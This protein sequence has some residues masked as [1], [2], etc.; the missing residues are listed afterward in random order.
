[1]IKVS[2]YKVELSE[3][4]V[5]KPLI[6]KWHYSHSV[7]G[8]QI[9][10]CFGLFGE[11][12]FGLPKL[13][14]GMIYGVPSS[15]MGQKSVRY[16]NKPGKVLELKRLCCI[17]DTPTNTESYFIGKTLKWLSKNTDYQVVVSYA[18]PDYGHSGTIYKASNFI[19]YGMTG[20][21]KVLMVDGEKY[22]RRFINRDFSA[23]YEVKKRYE[24]GDKNVYFRPTPEKHIY[25]YYLD[26][27]LK[28]K[29]NVL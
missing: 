17:D 16:G 23:A 10:Q 29:N 5:V 1:M 20:T 19:H 7:R 21:D 2:D 24:D 8:L 14:G 26:K 27:K 12:M 3:Y 9:S 6:E 28:R 4:K 18:D 15:R 22:H 25:I 13:I 11:D